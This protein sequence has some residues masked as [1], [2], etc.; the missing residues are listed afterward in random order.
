MQCSM[1]VDYNTLFDDISSCVRCRVFFFVWEGTF[2]G[3]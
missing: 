2:G 3:G 1:Q